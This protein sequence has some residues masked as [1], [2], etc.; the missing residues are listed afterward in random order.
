MAQEQAHSLKPPT[1]DALDE[2]F[3]EHHGDPSNH[4]WRVRM[5]HRF[6]YHSTPRRYEGFVD[7][8]VDG[9]CQW[10]DVGGGKSVFPHNTKL[11]KAL[12]KRCK[13]LVGVDPS[14]NIHQNQ[15]VHEG[16][17]STIEDFK[18]SELFDLATLRMVAEHVEHPKQAV[19][20]LARL[21][22][23]GGYVVILTPYKWAP[24]SIIAALVPNR[25]HSFFTGLLWNTKDEDVFPTRFRMNTRSAL[26]T[27][28]EDEAFDEAYFE[29]LSNCS[30]F[31]RF[32]LT[33]F[34]EL[35]IWKVLN[36]F[37]ITYPEND[38]LAIYQKR[39]G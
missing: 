32:P 26:K 34:I 10:L 27:L 17:E 5:H 20:A 6:G 39:N 13:H 36:R 9:D 28:F 7:Q 2:L 14:P 4:G 22:K 33:C 30:T 3:R 31:Q 24:V 8:L 19:Q 21:V 15:I 29:H 1:A 23:P 18:T 35:S 11:S 37:S 16:H 38:L 12:A 25:W